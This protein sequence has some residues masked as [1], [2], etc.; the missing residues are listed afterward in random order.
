MNLFKVSD[1]VAELDEVEDA[2]VKLNTDNK[3]NLRTADNQHIISVGELST[4]IYVDETTPP[5]NE[6][7]TGGIH[8]V[9][10]KF[11]WR[12]LLFPKFILI[13]FSVVIFNMGNSVIYTCVPAL[14]EESDE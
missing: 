11:E 4:H 14:G 3:E 13:L 7:K 1:D 6:S 10:E 2:H 8:E 5:I 9:K 12:I